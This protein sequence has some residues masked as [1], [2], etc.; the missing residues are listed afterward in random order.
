MRRTNED[1][2]T[3]PPTPQKHSELPPETKD[4]VKP[5]EID[6]GQLIERIRGKATSGLSTDEIMALTRG[7]A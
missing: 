2:V 4:R 3:T 7:E 6:G 5:A 1:N